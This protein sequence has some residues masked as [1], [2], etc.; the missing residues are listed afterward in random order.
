MARVEQ[1]PMVLQEVYMDNNEIPHEKDFE[2][3][4]DDARTI[5]FIDAKNEQVAWGERQR[6]QAPLVLGLLRQHLPAEVLREVEDFLSTDYGSECLH[7]ELSG[8]WFGL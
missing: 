6:A 4:G 8:Q 1:Q 2:E 3:M 5:A 7:H